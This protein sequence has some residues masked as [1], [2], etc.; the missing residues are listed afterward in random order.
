MV[1]HA[2]LHNEHHKTGSQWL[3]LR[4]GGADIDSIS[5]NIIGLSYIYSFYG[6]LVTASANFWVVLCKGVSKGVS[7]VSGN[8]SDF[9]N[10]KILV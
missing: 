10:L 8:W 4:N 3:V 6:G 1:H 7:E 2:L 5:K 9:F